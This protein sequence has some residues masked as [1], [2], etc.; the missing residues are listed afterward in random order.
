M[1]RL[2]FLFPVPDFSLEEL[3]WI[4]LSHQASLADL[5]LFPAWIEVFHLYFGSYGLNK[6]LVSS[7]F[8]KFQVRIAL[9]PK[10][11]PAI[12]V[13]ELLGSPFHAYV[14]YINIDLHFD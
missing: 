1:L 13:H 5:E 8:E 7:D 2:S 4:V 3:V 14:I 6:S 9:I 12:S 10:V 11:K